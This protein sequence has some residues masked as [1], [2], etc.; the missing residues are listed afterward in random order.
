MKVLV[1]ED[2]SFARMAVTKVVKAILPEVEFFE[3]GDG[4]K[5]LELFNTVHPDLVLTDLLMPKMTGDELI[6]EIRLLDQQVPIIVMSANVQKPAKAKVEAFGITGFI[7]KPIIGDSVKNLQ[8]LLM[9]CI[10]A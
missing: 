1:V 5:G 6:K 4:E 10:H 7:S 3:A 9:G 2:S 8:A